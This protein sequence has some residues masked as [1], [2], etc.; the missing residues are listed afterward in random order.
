[1]K[2]AKVFPDAL[3]MEIHPPGIG[4]TTK[5][6]N[7]KTISPFGQRVARIQFSTFEFLQKFVSFQN[8][9]A[10]CRK[11]LIEGKFYTEQE[12]TIQ[13]GEV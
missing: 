9:G 2:F 1:V 3:L 4:L 10:L 5:R 12:I 7:I 8:E 11:L 6:E 13:R